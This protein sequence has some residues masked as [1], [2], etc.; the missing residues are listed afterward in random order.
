[1]T[2]AEIIASVKTLHGVVESAREQTEKAGKNPSWLL[3]A[4]GAFAKAIEQL[5][6]HAQNNEAAPPAPATQ[7]PP[8]E[9]PSAKAGPPPVNPPSQVDQETAALRAAAK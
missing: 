9:T 1:M 3:V 7:S 6:L 2:T 4:R 8:A 5:N